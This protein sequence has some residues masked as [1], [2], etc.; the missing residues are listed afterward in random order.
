MPTSVQNPIVVVEAIKGCD[1]SD[2]SHPV[3]R[4]ASVER[5]TKRRGKGRLAGGGR[6]RD[7]ED[8]PP[9]SACEIH[10]KR[11][12]HSCDVRLDSISQLALSRT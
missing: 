5:I 3:R 7:A 9:L 2:P 12:K 10:G 1:G 6:P 8:V 11:G 4:P